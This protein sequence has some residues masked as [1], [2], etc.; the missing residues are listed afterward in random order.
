MGHHSPQSL[1]AWIISKRQACPTP[2][3][4]PRA[5]SPGDA[6]LLQGLVLFGSSADFCSDWRLFEILR[7]FALAEGLETPALARRSLAPGA[8]P[9][10]VGEHRVQQERLDLLGNELLILLL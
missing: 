4:I 7:L 3:T 9:M 10:R 5:P 8:T 1:R 6:K 2:E